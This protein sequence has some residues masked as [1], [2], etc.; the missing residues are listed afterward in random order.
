M[1][2]DYNYES[3]HPHEPV[4]GATTVTKVVVGSTHREVI[5][6]LW[7]SIAY[8]LRNSNVILDRKRA[9]EASTAPVMKFYDVFKSDSMTAP[10]KAGASSMIQL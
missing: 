8:G 1:R 6:V 2:Q 7:D 3:T 4:A 9:N 5:P 10:K